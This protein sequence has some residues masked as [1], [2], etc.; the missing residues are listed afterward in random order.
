MWILC[1]FSSTVLLCL[2]ELFLN[3]NTMIVIFFKR[4][5]RNI[6]PNQ[7]VS[8]NTRCTKEKTTKSKQ[9]LQGEPVQEIKTWKEITTELPSK[10]TTWWKD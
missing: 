9:Y 3:A 10:K 8:P 5:K 4:L 1:F 2:R 7:S 6:L